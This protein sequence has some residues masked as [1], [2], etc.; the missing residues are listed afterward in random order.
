M[1]WNARCL[2]ELY[3][4]SILNHLT[5]CAVSLLCSSP[6]CLAA[7]NKYL[8]W[9][10]LLPRGVF[11]GR[12]TL[13][14]LEDVWPFLFLDFFY[15]SL[16]SEVPCTRRQYQA[17]DNFHCL[18]FINF[19]STARAIKEAALLSLSLSL[20]LVCRQRCVYAIYCLRCV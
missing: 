2:R 13:V 7:T 6:L 1:P 4:N 20:S 5:R 10:P 9:Q 8:M 16:C 17:N 19:T 3:E 18:L 14:V 11:S 12:S 15:L